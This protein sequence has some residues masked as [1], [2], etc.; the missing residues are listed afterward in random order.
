MDSIDCCICLD[1]VNDKK[2]EC[3]YQV[4]C[5]QK[6]HKKCHDSLIIDSCPMCRQMISLKSNNKM[7]KLIFYISIT[8]FLCT[9]ILYIYLDFNSNNFYID[10]E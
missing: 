7:E 6:L 8:C 10:I 9:L 3:V 5:G 2:I 4:C 1:N